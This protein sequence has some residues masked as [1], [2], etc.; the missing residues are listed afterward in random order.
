LDFD[1]SPSPSGTPSLSI[2]E[3][4]YRRRIG[5]LAICSMSLFIVSLDVT[6]VNVALPSI[7]VDLH[8]SISGLQWIID[9]YT[10]VLASFLLL[11]GSAADRLG[12]RRTF[13]VGLSIFVVASLLCSVTPNLGLLVA[14]RM[15]QAIG[16][17]MLNPVAMSIITNTFT[18]P[19]ERAQAIGVWAAVMG[20]SMALGPVVGGLLVS[21]VGWRSIFWVNI[22]VGLLAIVLSLAFIP[23][24]RAARARRVDVPGQFLV[25]ALLSSLTYGIIEAPSRGWSSG[26]IVGAFAVAGTSLVVLLIVERR[27][28]EP[29]L[30]LR[31]FRSVPFAASTVIAVA[32]FAALG[33]F[34]FLNTLY[35]QDV[36]GLSALH[37]GI[38]TLPMAVMT[39]LVP[40][41]S[42]WIVGRHGS[43]IPLLIA[44][45]AMSAGCVMLIAMSPSTPYSWLFSAY[46]LFGLGFGFVNPPITHTAVSGMPRDQAGVASGIASSSRQVGQTLG[47]AVVGAIVTAGVG[48]R[49][50]LSIASASHAGW[51]VLAGAGIAVL[52]LGFVST[53]R[54]A[55]KSATRTAEGINPEWLEQ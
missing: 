31:F 19:R 25:I 11:S 53:S 13:V 52:L 5:I 44:G 17:S 24:S 20:V 36:R 6:I 39:M 55:L 30:D 38:D 37:A 41:L 23:E 54:L 2:H 12:R 22:P 15:L 46:M 16:G 26:L 8:A 18:V 9:G 7:R 4:S 1:M 14:F 49:N 45:A 47:V 51:W 27:R 28:R 32:S 21:S 42:G 48:G 43:R 33:G 10:L 3:L 40:P 35:L 34:L 50:H 29:L